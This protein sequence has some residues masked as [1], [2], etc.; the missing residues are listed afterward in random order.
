MKLL[1]PTA[2]LALAVA[3]SAQDACSAEI[4]AVPTCAASLPLLSA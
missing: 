1:L 3:V 2:I 4:A